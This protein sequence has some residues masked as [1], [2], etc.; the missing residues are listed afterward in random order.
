MLHVS[1]ELHPNSRK[2]KCERWL[3]EI[4]NWQQL[5]LLE[6]LLCYERPETI[7]CGIFS[8][9]SIINPSLGQELTAAHEVSDICVGV[10]FTSS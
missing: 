7:F 1:S 6:S 8:L 3:I 5:S 10:K 9:Y 4:E 2:L